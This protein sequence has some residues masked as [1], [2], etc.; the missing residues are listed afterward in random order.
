MALQAWTLL[1]LLLGT[2]MVFAFGFMEA[3]FLVFTVNQ[4]PVFADQVQLSY[5][6]ASTLVRFHPIPSVDGVILAQ[7]LVIVAV[8][9]LAVRPGAI[10]T[11]RPPNLEALAR[12]PE[13]AIAPESSSASPSPST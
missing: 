12:D 10:R 2:Q 7:P 1:A 5:F 8:S 13:A 6:Y 3:G 11:P 9:I 4:F